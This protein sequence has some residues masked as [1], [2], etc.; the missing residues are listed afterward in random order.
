MASSGEATEDDHRAEAREAHFTW[1]AGLPQKER[2]ERRS[3][4]EGDRNKKGNPAKKA[5][6]EKKP[7]A[8]KRNALLKNV[9][10]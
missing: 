6:R 9:T 3:A 1:H 4:K 5:L 8:V 10:D 7:V 2:G